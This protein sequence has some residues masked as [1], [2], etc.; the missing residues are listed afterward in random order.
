MSPARP[1]MPHHSS[2]ITHHST[3]LL[4]IGYRRN[5]LLRVAV[6]T[7]RFP[8]PAKNSAPENDE[9]AEN[10]RNP[11][12]A[13]ARDDEHHL[14]PRAGHGDRSV[15]DH[16]RSAQLLRRSR[17]PAHPRAEGAPQ[18]PA[19][20]HALRLSPHHQPRQS[21]PFRARPAPDHLLRRLGREC[22]GHADREAEGKHDR[23]RARQVV[24]S[25]RAGQEGRTLTMTTIF[26]LAA[27]LQAAGAIETML[28]VI[29]KATLILAIA[30][31]LLMA[32]PRAS[33]ATKHLVATAALVAV[34]A[35]PV[36]TVMVPAWNMAVIPN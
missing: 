11:Q 29:V 28:L 7:A 27:K 14:F 32:M 22:G 31:L 13:G 10:D 18:A 35:M 6:L 2:L 19:R 24:L 17:H 1:L 16:G 15:G 21:A 26:E 5:P 33:A 20:R 30:R 8:A 23:R 4:L 3:R 9:R 34:A 36:M 12:P 25:D